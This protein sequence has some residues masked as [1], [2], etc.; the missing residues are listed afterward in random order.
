MLTLPDFNRLK[1][2]YFVYKHRSLIG[3]AQSLSITR[4]AISQSLK[5]LEAE[6]RLKLF[7]R[8]SKRVVP[9][10]HGV[11]LFQ[12]IEP[13]IESL[14][15]IVQQL[16]TGQR[17]PAGHLRIGAPQDFG[18]MQLTEGI[19]EFRKKYPDVTFE[20]TLATPV[21]LLKLVSDGK[22]DLA[23]VDNGDIHAKDYPVSITTVMR[24]KF[25]L[26][27]SKKYFDGHVR[28][29]SPTLA[30]LIKLDFVDYLP[31]A[32]VTKIWMKHYFGKS[33]TDIR[34]SFSAESVRAVVRAVQ[35]GLGLGVVP[36]NLVEGDLKAGRLKAVCEAGR[37]LTNQ[38][39]LARPLERTPSA[40]ESLFVSF[41]KEFV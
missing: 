12:S 34:V 26:V 32:P 36:L 39:T 10:E 23:F 27:C 38:I 13:F 24:E 29:D 14:Q 6:L 4:S 22:L 9:T 31:H 37:G 21:T 30:N 33:V 7:L 28:Q 19:I 15:A 40:R 41:F 3:A 5:A 8:N 17:S 1:V 11:Q 35:G 25:V 2:F 16:E 20:L 18:S